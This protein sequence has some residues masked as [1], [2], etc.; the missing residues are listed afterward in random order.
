MTTALTP[1][2]DLMSDQQFARHMDLLEARE[3]AAR[4]TDR[5]LAKEMRVYGLLWEDYETREGL[6]EVIARCWVG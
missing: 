2:T 6:N 5:P 1:R 4:L 3:D